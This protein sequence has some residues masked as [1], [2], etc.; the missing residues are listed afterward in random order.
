M[1]DLELLELAVNSI[2]YR[3][4]RSWLAILGVVIGVASII[5]LISI[6][7]GL[8]DQIQKQLGGLGSNLITISPGGL[9]AQR[10]GF[11]GFGGGERGPSQPLT[12]R[13]ADSLRHLPG[14]GL[15]DARLSRNAVVHYRSKNSSISVVGTE[16]AAF[17]ASA[18]AQLLEG[19]G[20]SGEGPQAVLGFNVMNATF[21]EDML[22][23]PIQINGQPFRVVGILNATGATF[24]GPDNSIFIPQKAAQNLFSQEVNASSLVVITASG[25]TP[26]EVAGNL[27]AALLKLHRVSADKQDFQVITASSLQSTASSV[28]GTLA[29]FLGVIASI[30]LLV[31]GIG[32]ANAMFTSVLEQTKYIGI[33]KALGARRMEIMK[34]FLFEAGL[35]GLVGGLLGVILSYGVSLALSQFGLPTRI[36]PELVLLGMFFSVIVGAVSGVLPSRNAASVPPVEALRYE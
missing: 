17:P 18:N 8:N 22:N 24:G 4:L 9:S 28:T 2:R 34:L 27:T 19:R 6:S 10:Q 13:Q 31:G 32:V 14:V 25:Y 21:K 33:L 35:V 29:L 15:L 16:P 11:S 1:K 26:D 20:F 3:S 30:S 12:F 5:S 23:K 7:T 36:T